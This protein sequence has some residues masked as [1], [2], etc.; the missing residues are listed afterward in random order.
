MSSLAN[1]TVLVVGGSSGLGFGAAKAAHR[2]GAK[3]ILA[4]SSESKI[5]AAVQRLGGPSNTLV[6]AV[7]DV[8]TEGGVKAFF[9]KHGAV[10]HVVYTVCTGCQ[11]PSKALLTL[12][13]F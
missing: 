13:S 12:L 3:V 6:G 5:A 1:Q 7:I 4:S 10:D 9:E 8:K 2:E 11:I